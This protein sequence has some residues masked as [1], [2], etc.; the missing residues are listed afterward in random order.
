[1]T[2]NPKAIFDYIFGLTG[3]DVKLELSR[4]HQFMDYL[5]NPYRSYPVIHIAGTNGKGSTAAILA[6]ILRGYGYKVGLF[7][8]PHLIIPNERIKVNDKLVPDAYIVAKVEQWRDQIEMLGITFFEVLTALGMVYFK[9]QQVDYAVIETGLG[10]RLDATNVVNPLV[11]VITS[12]SKD[13]ENIL[14]HTLD[15]IAM[16]KAGI[17]KPGK[18]VVLG[19]NKPL[20][21]KLVSD[22]ADLRHSELLKVSNQIQIKSARQ[23]EDYQ[24]IN[25]TLNGT[26]L[27][28]KLPLLGSY[29][30]E[31]F[32]NALV[33]L[34]A[35]NIEI[36]EQSIQ[37]GLDGLKWAGRMQILKKEPRVIYD[38][39]H[40]PEGLTRL[41]ES[42]VSIGMEDAILLAAFNARK[43]VSE[44][45]KILSS[46]KGPVFYTLFEGHSAVT[47]DVLREFGI[48]PI[49]MIESPKEAY[50][51]ALAVRTEKQ[52]ICFLG[53][54]YLAENIYPIFEVD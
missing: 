35:M 24:Q 12:I 20:I 2:P 22:V 19:Q 14:G 45:V 34:G 42:L 5:G 43:D 53:S 7:T 47:T 27:S 41:L 3:S 9:E 25:L 33:A 21:Q 51:T 49:L 36:N 26:E 50:E 46:W 23:S 6:S 54:H 8:S 28:F 38:V 17:I 31:N 1:M 40:N 15:E 52:A 16:E 29:Q 30:V 44:L 37:N 4:V 32:S 11:S 48:D 39:A 10:G 18:P 13:H